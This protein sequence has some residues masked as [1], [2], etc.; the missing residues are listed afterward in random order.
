MI[1]VLTDANIKFKERQE[2]FNALS[3]ER[4][5]TL[6]CVPGHKGVE[7]NKEGGRATKR[8]TASEF[9]GSE[10]S[11]GIPVYLV[12]MVINRWVQRKHQ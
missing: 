4:R 1:K 2:K 7:G 8:G 12:K 11:I 9:V 6:H 5:I 3:L 10:L